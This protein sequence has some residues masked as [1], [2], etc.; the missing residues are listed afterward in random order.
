LNEPQAATLTRIAKGVFHADDLRVALSLAA[1]FRRA[2]VPLLRTVIALKVGLRIRSLF[3]F[4]AFWSPASGRPVTFFLRPRPLILR[5]FGS[6]RDRSKFASR[7][8][9]ATRDPVE[10]EALGLNCAWYADILLTLS[11]G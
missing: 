9:M 1:D 6:P 2:R 5:S 10:D 8:D 4:R 11:E 7:F 3:L